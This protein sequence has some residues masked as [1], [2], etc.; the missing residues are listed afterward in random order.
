V[1]FVN[2]G[3]KLT[4]VTAAGFRPVEIA[5]DRYS[6]ASWRFDEWPE[7]I[8]WAADAD[9][10]PALELPDLCGM[11][12]LG[13]PVLQPRQIFGIGLNYRSHAIESELDVPSR[14]P[15]FTKFPTCIA[16]PMSEIALHSD[17]VD[18]EAELV[19]IMGRPACRVRAQDAWNF[20][21]G[22]TVGQDITDR[23]DQWAGPV[24]QFSMAKSYVGFGPIGPVMV[25][26][27]E[28]EDPDDL[29]IVCDVNGIVVQQ[30]RTSDMIFSVSEIIEELSRI[31]LLQPG[32]LIFTGTPAGVGAARRPRQY[33]RPGDVIRTSIEGIGTIVNRCLAGG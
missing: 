8:A 21:A 13:P 11:K 26:P 18:W 1:R 4:L 30:E 3:G 14:P 6:C 22:L 31:V 23:R 20:V 12:A 7:I 2:L 33:L 17:Y 32:D 15:V 25:T 27:D 24:P 10:G 29:E 9:T 5:A 19:V 28:F 16:G